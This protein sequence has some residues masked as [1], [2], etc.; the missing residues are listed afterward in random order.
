MG[1]VLGSEGSLI[2]HRTA[3]E[4]EGTLQVDSWESHPPAPPADREAHDLILS[5]R[6]SASWPGQTTLRGP[7]GRGQEGQGQSTAVDFQ[8][9]SVHPSLR[10]LRPPGPTPFQTSL[11]SPLSWEGQCHGCHLPFAAIPGKLQ[12]PRMIYREVIWI[13]NYFLSS[14]LWVLQREKQNQEGMWGG[15]RGRQRE[16]DL[17]KKLAHLTVGAG[18]SESHRGCWKFR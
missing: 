1:S 13:N 15:R 12:R 2:D 16:G 7:E 9:R 3:Q 4:R 14:C 17:F 18:K 10:M 6:H 8:Q 11:F 5:G